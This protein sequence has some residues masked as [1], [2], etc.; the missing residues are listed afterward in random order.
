[1]ESEATVSTRRGGKS[2]RQGGRL[3]QMLG[4]AAGEA[5]SQSAHTRCNAFG[6][7]L[8][9]AKHGKNEPCR[10]VQAEAKRQAERGRSIRGV[11][12]VHTV[13]GRSEKAGRRAKMTCAVM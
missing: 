12:E 11:C 3:Q 8:H 9:T 7:A 2:P 10:A 6:S 13:A 5:A 1:V 4:G